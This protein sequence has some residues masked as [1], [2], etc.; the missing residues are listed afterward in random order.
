MEPHKTKATDL[1]IDS[2]MSASKFARLAAQPPS[3]T[4]LVRVDLTSQGSFGNTKYNEL[5]NQKKMLE[6]EE[7]ELAKQRSGIKA[8]KDKITRQL[9]KIETGEM[10]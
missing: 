1:Q 5:V 4:N 7:V 10:I 3:G 9:K 2:Q 8:E 6:N